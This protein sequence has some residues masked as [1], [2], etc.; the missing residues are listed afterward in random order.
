MSIDLPTLVAVAT[1]AT[2]V[3]GLMLLFAWLQDRRA[4][5]LGLWGAGLVMM[6]AGSALLALRGIIPLYW[7]IV[8]GS[9]L[10]LL[11][12]GLMWC[13][14]RAFEGRRAS[15]AVAGA[16]VAIWLL[17]CQ[18]DAFLSSMTMRVEL[19][20]LL[21]CGYALLTAAEYWR[22]RDTELMSRWPAIVLLLIHGAFFGVRAVF[23]EAMPFP[24]VIQNSTAAWFPLAAAATLA[25][26]FC[27]AFLVMN[28][29]KERLELQHRRAALVDPLTGIANRRAFFERGERVLQRTLGEGRPVALLVLDLDLFKRI[30]DTFGHQTGDR[31]LCAFC[32]TAVALLRPT[33]LFG[34]MGG[35]EFACLLPGATED[36]AMQVAERIRATFCGRGVDVGG[37][38]SPSTVS[39]G[40][41][42]MTEPGGELAV[43]FAAADRA[44]YQAKAKGRNRV[45]QARPAVVSLQPVAAVA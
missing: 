2:T 11:S 42:T 27:M 39:I 9:C 8:A 3:S 31:V 19:Y 18:F 4:G 30:N 5:T 12:Y 29:A 33:D 20:S 13:G 22:A 25:H 28:M 1:F 15:A 24:T 43:L 37:E 35:E 32:E 36:E 14:A 21:A 7:S 45:E 41:A 40:V 34:R 38:N 17:A 6:A 26:F 16:G 10:C 23:A 44:L